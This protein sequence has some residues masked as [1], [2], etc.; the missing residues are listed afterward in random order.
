MRRV[1]ARV[2]ITAMA[3][4][5]H[6][7]DRAGLLNAIADEGFEEVAGRISALRLAGDLEKRLSAV[8]NVYIDHTLENPKLFE[9]MFLKPRAGA[10]RF[11]RDFKAGASPTANLAAALIE[12][13]MKSGYF[14]KDDAWEITFELGALLEGLIMLYLGGRT[15]LSPAQF[16]ALCHR[17]FRRYFHGIRS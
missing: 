10:R 16:R 7:P 2:G 9:V 14:R 17:S 12:E 13:G 6:Y 11:P 15:S 3:L 1:A 5:R 4:Y 8:L